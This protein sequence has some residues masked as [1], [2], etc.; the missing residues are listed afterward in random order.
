MSFGQCSLLY[1]VT[2]CAPLLRD[3]ALHQ[4]AVPPPSCTH[5]MHI[6]C[7]QKIRPK[8]YSKPLFALEFLNLLTLKWLNFFWSKIF[9]GFSPWHPFNEYLRMAY[10]N[11]DKDRR[12]YLIY[13]L[14]GM[15]SLQFMRVG[16]CHN[17]FMNLSVFC[18]HRLQTTLGHISQPLKIE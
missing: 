5:S 17:S 12:N 8:N 10:F 7:I 2:V 16:W 15:T 1:P 13:K 18:S 6:V 9:N 3:S 4:N 14:L 11:T